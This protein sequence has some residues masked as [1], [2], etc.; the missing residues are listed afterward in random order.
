[1][2]CSVIGHYDDRLLIDGGALAFSK[3]LC[4]TFTTYG[5]VRGY[6]ELQLT[7]ITQE[8]CVVEGVTKEHFEKV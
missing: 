1:V 3:D 4:G 5:T 8:V 2:L 6:P 7:K